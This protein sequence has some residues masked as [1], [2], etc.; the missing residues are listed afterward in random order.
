MTEDERAKLLASM[1]SPTDDDLAALAARERAHMEDGDTLD[2]VL[3]RLKAEGLRA[4][5]AFDV[6]RRI[7]YIPFGSAKELVDDGYHGR[8]PPLDIDDLA[9]LASMPR[10]CRAASLDAYIRWAVV[11]KDPFLR[12]TSNKHDFAERCDEIKRAITE[13]LEWAREIEIVRD[14]DEVFEIRFVRVP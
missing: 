14:D 2:I 12:M 7:K 10:V 4:L 13:E 8:C 3:A 11:N 5:H 9:L 1:V 6:L